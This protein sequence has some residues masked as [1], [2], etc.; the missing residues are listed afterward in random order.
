LTEWR[1]ARRL[2]YNVRQRKVSRM[3]SV[4]EYDEVKTSFPKVFDFVESPRG[5]TITI[6]RKGRPVARL[7]P[8]RVY[9]TTEADPELGGEIKCDL[10]ADE[11]SD[12]ENA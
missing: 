7:S 5:C 9:R 4:L 6:V 1:R 8:I 10:F 11:S 12:W 3:P 2:W